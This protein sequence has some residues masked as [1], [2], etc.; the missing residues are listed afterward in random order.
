MDLS[1]ALYSIFTLTS[2]FTLRI[3]SMAMA[4][5]NTIPSTLHANYGRG[6]STADAR[7]VIQHPENP[8]IST[9]D[10]YEAGAS[11][12]EGRLSIS[13]DFFLIDRSHE[14]VYIP[15]NAT[16]EFKGPSRAYGF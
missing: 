2:R 5:S 12:S 16:Y 10:F 14:E 7:V 8:R 1:L 9:T 6:I 3:R 11:H 15:D 4:S 13:E